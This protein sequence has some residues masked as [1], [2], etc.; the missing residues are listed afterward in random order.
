[1]TTMRL[2]VLTPTLALLDTAVTK[3]SAEAPNGAFALL[4]RHIDLVT[5]LAAGVL[6]Y[7][8]GSGSERFI[9]HDEGT[10][11]KRGADVFVTTRKAAL[12]DDLATLE[13]RVAQEFLKRDETEVQARSALARL[14][15]GVMRRF[16]E[17]GGP[18]P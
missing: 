5:A 7:V 12:G 9:G 18:A 13:A 1:M 17:L 15:A 6:A 10:L 16:V 2:R 14:E 11:V 4:P 8:D 3:I